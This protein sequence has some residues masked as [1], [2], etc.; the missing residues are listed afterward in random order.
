MVCPC[1]LLVLVLVYVST[2]GFGLV[3]WDSSICNNL[4]NK[5]KILDCVH[6]CLSVIRTEIPD[7]SAPTVNDDE[8]LLISIIL[9]SLVSEEKISKSDLKAHSD[10]RR[11]Y[12]MEHFRWGK[13]SRD[14]MREPK[15]RGHSDER[16]SYSMEHFRWGK[17]SGRKRRPVKVFA[18]SLEGGGPSGGRFPPQARR[19][20]RSNEDEAKGDVSGGGQG[21]TRPRVGSKSNIVMGLQQRKDGSYRMSHFR[22]GS[23]HTAKRNGRFMKQWEE[24]PQGKLARLFRNI[25]VKDVQR[26]MV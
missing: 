18:T 14:K 22:W 24:R 2:P 26:I 1:W 12:T 16:R 25:I 21:Q 6:H 23:P 9:A 13:P 19:Q 5:E 10:G 7:L 20:L 3:C 11:S 15:L 4:S 8:D 17:P